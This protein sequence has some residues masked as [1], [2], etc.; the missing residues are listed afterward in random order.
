M[1]FGGQ[2]DETARKY[3][4]RCPY[5]YRAECGDVDCFP[6]GIVSDTHADL[7]GRR[8]LVVGLNANEEDKA[9]AR[10]KETR[11]DYSEYV[12]DQI[13][14]QVSREK[15]KCLSKLIKPVARFF[16]GDGSRESQLKALDRIN[17]CNLVSC[18]PKEGTSASKPSRA[19]K[20]NCIKRL[21]DDQDHELLADWNLSDP[22]TSSSSATMLRNSG[23]KP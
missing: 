5:P 9:T 15:V 7:D 14:G 21:V 23:I 20:T 13:R 10:Q 8:L 12:K 19:M 2:I 1:E 16:W 11:R 22:P 4:A 18:C 3:L 6:W 17:W